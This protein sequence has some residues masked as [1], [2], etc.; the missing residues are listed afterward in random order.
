[1][2]PINY[3]EVPHQLNCGDSVFP[4]VVVNDGSLTTQQACADWFHYISSELAAKFRAS[5]SLLFRG[6]PDSSAVTCV[7]FSTYCVPQLFP[8]TSLLLNHALRTF[9]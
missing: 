2:Q 7:E 4:S 5:V 6:S 9:T 8:H 3:V 1:M